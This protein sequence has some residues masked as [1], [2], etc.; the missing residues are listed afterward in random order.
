MMPLNSLLT[1]ALWFHVSG[2]QFIFWDILG[3][4][5]TVLSASWNLKWFAS[6]PIS[7]CSGQYMVGGGGLKQHVNYNISCNMFAVLHSIAS[8]EANWMSL[9]LGVFS[10]WFLI[11]FGGE[12]RYEWWPFGGGIEADLGMFERRIQFLSAPGLWF[13]C[14]NS[15][16]PIC[17]QPTDWARLCRIIF[18]KALLVPQQ[19]NWP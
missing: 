19:Q 9:A 16:V 7:T 14:W 1:I 4:A 3:L 12:T 8:V 17:L 2:F 10:N 5:S 13:S 18:F 11:S 15:I 6:M